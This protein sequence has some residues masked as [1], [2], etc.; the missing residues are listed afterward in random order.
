M[1]KGY[2]DRRDLGERGLLVGN[3]GGSVAELL[4]QDVVRRQ[5]LIFEVSSV[6]CLR[7]V[8]LNQGLFCPSRDIW[9]YL[10]TFLIIRTREGRDATGI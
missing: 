10:E 8:I 9:Q 1:K 3:H 6:G 7:S 5:M 2:Y 4:F